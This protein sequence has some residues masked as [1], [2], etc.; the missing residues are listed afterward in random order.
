M[1]SKLNLVPDPRASRV[2][3]G[4]IPNSGTCSE[5]S[6]VLPPV[7]GGELEA[8]V[9]VQVPQ[10]IRHTVRTSATVLAG[11]LDLQSTNNHGL[12]TQNEAYLCHCFGHFGGPDGL[13]SPGTVSRQLVRGLATGRWLPWLS[14]RPGPW[15][16]A[17]SR[18]A[19]FEYHPG[20]QTIQIPKNKCSKC[21]RA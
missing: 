6:F 8:S 16:S 21:L 17:R 2:R 18:H 7:F 15:L 11:G 3:G 10:R 5:T 4:T 14:Q 12:S 19:I 20:T 1:W 13:Y 9:R